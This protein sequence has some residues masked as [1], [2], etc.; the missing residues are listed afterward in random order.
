[1]SLASHRKKC[2]AREYK[3]RGRFPGFLYRQKTQRFQKFTHQSIATSAMVM[4]V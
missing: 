2:K 3:N 4:I 1:M